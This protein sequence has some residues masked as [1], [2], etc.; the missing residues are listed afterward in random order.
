MPI[1]AG[2]NGMTAEQLKVLGVSGSLRRGSYNTAALR[3]AQE[4]APEEMSIE[5]GAIGDIPIYNADVQAQGFPAP[6][7]ALAEKMRAADAVL[8]ATPEYNYSIPGGLKNAIDWLSRLPEQPFAGKPAGM[9][10]A[11]QSLLGAARAQYH[12]RQCF[13]FLDAL[14]MNKPEVFI[15]LAQNKFDADG[16]LT[17]EPTRGFIAANL[18]ALARWIRLV[19]AG[20]AALRA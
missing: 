13:V 7:T 20:Q 14:P 18:Q 9:I 10:S 1:Q 8:I 17:D 11:S 3:A 15:T 2:G 6:V 19:Q 5:I 16:R 4:L 12:L